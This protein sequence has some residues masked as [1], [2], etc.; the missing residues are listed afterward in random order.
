MAKKLELKRLYTAAEVAMYLGV[1]EN[2]VVRN[3]RSKVFRGKKVGPRKRWH[4]LG[5]DVFKVLKRWGLDGNITVVN[6]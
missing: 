1:V 6:E 2:T 4:M 5:E 3:C